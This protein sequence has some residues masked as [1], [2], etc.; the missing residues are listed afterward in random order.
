[1]HTGPWR[2]RAALLPILALA[3]CAAPALGGELTPPLLTAGPVSVTVDGRSG[4]EEWASATAVGVFLDADGRPA[5]R[6][7]RCLIGHDATGIA[8]SWWV[9]GAPERTRRG[10]D[11][12]LS[13]DDTV[14]VV[15]AAAAEAPVHRFVVS[16]S[17]DTLE[18][19]DGDLE[20]DCAWRALPLV[21]GDQWRV[22][23]H[24]PFAGLQAPVPAAGDT[25]R[26]DLRVHSSTS[27]SASSWA[28]P[29]DEATPGFL[30][31][32]DARSPVA[33][34]A[35]ELAGDTV[36]VRPLLSAGASLRATLFDGDAEV[37]S[38]ETTASEP[39]TV[40]PPRPGDFR[41]RLAG[42]D[43]AGELVLQ[44]EIALTREPPLVVRA[45]RRLLGRR[46]V[47]LTIMTPGLA[48]APE[49]FVVAA[50]G[51]EALTIPPAAGA[52]RATVDLSEHAEP[53]I[54][55]TVAA[56]AGEEEL[57][58]ESL[59]VALPEPPAWAGNSLGRD[60]RLPDP[61]TPVVVEGSAVRY[62]GG[63]CDFGAGPLPERMVA[64]GLNVLAGPVR[65]R[66]SADGAPQAWEAAPVRWVE[67]TNT[68]AVAVI[69]AS[70]SSV[71]LR[72]RAVCDFDGLVTFDMRVDPL[73]EQRLDGVELAIPVATASG[74][75]VRVT[76][77]VNGE[78]IRGPAPAA[79]W[80]RAFAPDVWLG[81]HERGLQFVCA[82]DE[83]WALDEPGRAL[84]ILRGGER[85]T[86]VVRMVDRALL[87]GMGFATSFGLQATPVRPL[88]EG[89]R[90]RRCAIVSATDAD[91][92]SGIGSGVRTLIVDI[93][94]FA[95]RAEGLEPDA[96][97]ELAALVEAAHGWGMKVLLVADATLPG[98]PAW[99]AY[100]DEVGARA[101]DTE[102]P[103]VGCPASAWADYL[104]ASVARAIDDYAVDGVYL[105]GM[106]A[107]SACASAMHGCGW[108]DAAG[109]HPTWDITT[110]REL[111][112]RVRSVIRARVPDGLLT[113]G[114]EAGAIA[115]IVSIADA[116]L[117]QATDAAGEP[118]SAD[119][120]A[121]GSGAALGVPSEVVLRGG[122]PQPLFGALSLALLHDLPPCP[123]DGELAID[124]AQSVWSTRDDFAPET[125]S[126]WAYWATRSPVGSDAPD[127]P[128]SAFTRR[129]EAL[130]AVANPRD[131]RIIELTLDRD[132]LDLGDWLTATNAFA[133]R[134]VPQV[135]A[136]LRLRPQAGM[137]ALVWVRTRTTME[138]KHNDE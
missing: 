51:V 42:V 104:V 4:G 20:W 30:R 86:L 32:A 136:V 87:P 46:E 127:V 130:V 39:L 60:A 118:L 50:P 54:T 11:G 8:L 109:R 59:T 107:V 24:I 9:Q 102:A 61:W 96:A 79:G 10:H 71:E 6:G 1:M 45:V 62:L 81:D 82:S 63:L 36:T 137:P 78:P 91:A 75:L 16:A 99:S 47:A 125:A 3:T 133:P 95:P 43:A 106:G 29:S 114:D 129:G 23:M 88:P 25:W 5:G 132:R 40:T 7:A 98:E 120:F 76:D 97:Q 2:S 17:G 31:F 105:R 115:P 27:G 124:F 135:G 49:R 117:C 12:D 83:G 108:E 100:A 113:V 73:A 37:S 34:D 15:L 48:Q 53:E 89:W 33:I 21:A 22:E 128:V 116:V 93:P 56:M 57:A 138:A 68:H 122:A 67:T 58:R 77:A 70:G 84:S 112:R 28:P 74:A 26:L 126:W 134:E 94:R 64:G 85:T 103:T 131:E 90:G 13:G 72:L 18:A 101:D 52:T 121:A 55:L 41:L 123:D 66:V 65:V 35:L 14:E 44:R 80:Q 19:R 110:A 119:A 111:V 92:C 38:T 69:S